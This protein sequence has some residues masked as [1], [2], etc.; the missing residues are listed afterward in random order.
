LGS[1]FVPALIPDPT[2]RKPLKWAISCIVEHY[3]E[4]ME[5]LLGRPAKCIRRQMLPYFQCLYLYSSCF[6]MNAPY[7]VPAN[8]LKSGGCSLSPLR[9]PAFQ[10]HISCTILHSRSLFFLRL[11]SLKQP[12]ENDVIDGR[13]KVNANPNPDLCSFGQSLLGC[14]ALFSYPVT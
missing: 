13:G 10:F 5:V 8:V 2:G 4:V 6:T 12:K 7:P 1:W 9:R 14:Q 3:N 11:E